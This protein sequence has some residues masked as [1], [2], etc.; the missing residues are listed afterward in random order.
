MIVNLK[1]ELVVRCLIGNVGG[2]SPSLV[3]TSEIV[4][5][6]TAVNK[7]SVT[8]SSLYCHRKVRMTSNKITGSQSDMSSSAHV[9][10]P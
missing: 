5:P 4:T 2:T 10:A 3:K 6:V 1:C 8:S 9:Q 7:I